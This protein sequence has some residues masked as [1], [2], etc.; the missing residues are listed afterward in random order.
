[1]KRRETGKRIMSMVLAV[2]MALSLLPIAE[3]ESYAKTDKLMEEFDEIISTYNIDDSI[4]SYKN[5]IAQYATMNR[6]DGSIEIPAGDYV[7]YEEG[8]AAA[9]PE[10]YTDYEGMT[11]DSVLTSEDSLIEFEVNVPESGLYNLSVVYYSVEGKNSDIERS[12]FIDGE[13]PFQEMALLT[14][15]RVWINYVENTY[16]D[17]N[18]VLIKEWEKD[19]QGNDVKPK[20]MEAPEWQSRYCYDSDGYVTEPLSIYLE[21]GEH[22]I[23]MV[24][25]KEPMLINKLV[26]DSE[27][28]IASYEEVMAAWEANGA[29][30][31]I[32][33]VITIEGEY[34]SKTSSQMLYPQQ[35]QSSPAISPSSP[36]EL[37]NNSIGGNSW[38]LVGQWIEWEFEVPETGYYC[39]SLYDKQN[40]QRG[41]HV[42]RRITID[43]E[44]P[45]AEMAEYAFDYSQ[46]WREDIL[47]DENGEAYRFYLEEGKHTIRMEVVLGEFSEIVG[48]VEES[49]QQLNDIYRQVI[50]VTGVSPDTFRDYQL[51]ATL[52]ELHD[53]LVEARETLNQALTL[54]EQVAGKNTD[55]KTVLLTMLDQLDELIEDEE[56]FVRTITSYKINV[57]ALG[58]WITQVIG[59]PL[60]VD[61]IHVFSPDMDV[62]T[63]NDNFFAS[64]GFELQRLYYSFIIDYNNIGS[65]S[66]DGSGESITLWIGSGRDQ[67]N[68]IKA[69]IDESFTPET[70]IGV[71]VQLVDMS[72]LL[73][74]TLVG[75]GPDVAIQVANTNGIAGAVLNTGND[76]PV[77]YGIRNAVLDLSQFED[78]DEVM[79]RFPEAATLQFTYEDAIYGLPETITYPVMFYRKDILAEIGLEVPETWDEVKVA[80]TVLAKNQMEFGML[81]TEQIFASML[82]QNGGAYY[83]EDGTASALDS[84]IAVATF[85]EF[86]EYY[87]DYKLDKETSV[88]ERFRTGE[89]PIMIADY[90]TYNNF[91][92]SAPDIA[93]LWSFT[94]IPGTVQ[95]DGTIDHS[96]ASTGLASMIMADTEHPDA[97]WE[98]VKWWSSAE[99][100][101]AYGREMEG[102]MGSAARVPTANY[103]AFL[104]MPWPVDDFEALKE[105]M[106]CVKGIPQVPGGYYS[107][108]NVYNAFYTVVTETDTALPREELMDKVIYINAEINYKREELG[109]DVANEE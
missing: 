50:K 90:T 34:A 105:S 40:F 12:I 84:D 39:I 78:A 11:G 65:V 53:Q 44:V 97:S 45:F 85:K 89:C 36:K 16:Y 79:A 13:L 76:T 104:N 29:E 77:N 93:G 99:T 72:T 41:I 22:T 49:V 48:L 2:V 4:L 61:R 98:F 67:A 92:V 80:M 94:Q 75:E 87:T 63:A 101:T 28:V 82:Y 7:R 68:V 51:A 25:V 26:L 102:L 32:G 18:G 42:S 5:Y 24:S 56:Y 58:T 108:R 20:T 100:Q 83:N 46:S 59:Q 33:N 52:P 106:E 62:E 23:S 15:P 70:G 88:E 60:Q 30:D 10:I 19:N 31:T 35:D 73:K 43:G 1:M 54:L 81:P 95:E 74:A 107:W 8:D 86:C 55:K 109:L 21:A 3:M 71:N 103:E 91:A 17:E 14:F 57:R 64:A 9:V 69:L 37:L 27:G 47:C 6:P 66:E 96:V 38:R